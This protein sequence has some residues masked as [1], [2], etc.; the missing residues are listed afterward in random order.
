ML[1]KFDVFLEKKIEDIENPRK[2]VVE[3]SSNHIY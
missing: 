3:F 2:L 1:V